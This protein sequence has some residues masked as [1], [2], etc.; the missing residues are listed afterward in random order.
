[1][2][3]MVF[4]K[5]EWDKYA[6]YAHL[7]CFDEHRPKEMN[8]YDFALVAEEDGKPL[9][10]MTCREFDSETIYM[11][12]GGSFPSAKG[13]IK[14]FRAYELCLEYLSKQ[15]SQGTTLIENDNYPMLKF[16]MKQGLKVIGVRSFKDSVLL[17][18]LII[19]KE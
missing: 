9:T 4:P 15:Y 2:N 18:H 11:A 7:V 16:A 19:W 5:A 17:E 6:E 12:Y 13:T 1:M 3:L 14:S 10:Y 8:R